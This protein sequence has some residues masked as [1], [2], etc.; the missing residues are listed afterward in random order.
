MMTDTL[1][2]LILVEDVYMKLI[3]VDVKIKNVGM[4][5]RPWFSNEL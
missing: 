4:S 1:M 5:F 2:K 3:L